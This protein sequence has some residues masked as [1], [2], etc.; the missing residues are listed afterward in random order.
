MNLDRWLNYAIYLETNQTFQKYEN[1]QIF[2]QVNVDQHTK[3]L[4]K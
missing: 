1:M 2:M 3:H 4:N